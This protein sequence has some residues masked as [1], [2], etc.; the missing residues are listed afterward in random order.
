MGSGKSVSMRSNAEG[1]K[2]GV[3][4]GEQQETGW[5]CTS[6]LSSP[7]SYK[8]PPYRP[9]WKEALRD[10]PFFLNLDGDFET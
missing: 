5:E 7:G 4:V 3:R 9:L 8:G 10:F 2:E 1:K 6:C